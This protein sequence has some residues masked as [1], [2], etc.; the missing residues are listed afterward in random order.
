[1]K[2]NPDDCAPVEVYKLLIGSIT[3][4]PIAFVSSVDTN[5]QPRTVQ[6]LHR[7]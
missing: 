2:I 1:M 3:P 4:R 5:A 6:F 7:H